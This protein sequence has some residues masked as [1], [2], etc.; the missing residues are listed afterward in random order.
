MFCEA[1]N[2]GSPCI[3]RCSQVTWL[4]SSLLNT[5]QIHC[6]F[7]HSLQ[8]LATVINS[9]RLLICM[10]PSPTSA[11]TGRSGW[12]NLAAIAYGTPEPMVARV[13][14]SEPRMSPRNLMSR[15][16]QLAADPESQVTIAFSGMRDESSQKTRCGLTG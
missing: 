2:F 7:C 10:A 15:A 16:Y 11:T 4:R 9:A 6:G 13:P 1:S 3:T 8:Y 5:Q 12:A 14:E